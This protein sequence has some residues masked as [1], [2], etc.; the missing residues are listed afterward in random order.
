MLD[1]KAKGD[2]LRGNCYISATRF[3]ER[4]T[5]AEPRALRPQARP[6]HSYWANIIEHA[7][8]SCSTDTVGQFTSFALALF[9]EGSAKGGATVSLRPAE[10]APVPAATLQVAKAAFPKGC[11]AM[12]MRD[13]LGAIYDDQ[14]FASV[15]PARANRRTHRGAWRSLPCCSSPRAC[16]TDRQPTP[17][18]V[19]STG[20]MRWA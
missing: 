11:P 15:Y 2:R 4:V 18:G 12:R 13:E 20:S 5:Y 9:A 6:R 1:E 7:L 16:R 17:S 14:M 8:G 10:I 3:H 19:G